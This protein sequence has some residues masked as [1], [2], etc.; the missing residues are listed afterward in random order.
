MFLTK[1]NIIKLGDFGI[2]KTLPTQIDFTKTFLGTP[3]FMSPEVCK[4]DPYG[5]KADIWAIGCALYET[6][7][8]KR[9]YQDDNIKVLFEKI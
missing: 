9:P 8:L 5:T 1:D 3:Y 4:G 7:M 2:S 6:I